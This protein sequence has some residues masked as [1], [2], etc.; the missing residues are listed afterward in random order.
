MSKTCQYSSHTTG[1]AEGLHLTANDHTSQLAD[2][3]LTSDNGQITAENRPS[4]CGRSGRGSGRSLRAH[5]N[6]LYQPKEHAEQESSAKSAV[7]GVTKAAG[8]SVVNWRK[9][10]GSR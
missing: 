3:G 6:R 5:L 8:E 2:R 9:T 7:K 4:K 1:T 10:S